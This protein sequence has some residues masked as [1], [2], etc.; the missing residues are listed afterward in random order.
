MALR[1]SG[2]GH[3]RS[4]SATRS[5][6]SRATPGWPTCHWLEQAAAALDATDKVR[7]D[8]GAGARRR[9]SSRP[10]R[11]VAHVRTGCRRRRTRPPAGQRRHRAGP[12]RDQHVWPR[13]HRAPRYV[14]RVG[15]QIVV[16][17]SIL[18]A[19]GRSVSSIASAPG[20]REGLLGSVALRR[21]RAPGALPARRMVGPAPTA[22]GTCRQRAST[23]PSR[24]ATRPVGTC[25]P[26]RPLSQP[27]QFRDL[28][29]QVPLED[30]G[31][32]RFPP[33]P[34]C[35]RREAFRPAI[36]RRRDRFLGRGPAA[37]TTAAR[38][39]V[40]TPACPA[41]GGSTHPSRHRTT[42]TSI[43]GSRRGWWQ[44]RRGTSPS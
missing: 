39:I 38:P 23:R 34:E 30:L 32:S 2:L 8:G 29:A 10:R 41:C 21:C 13:D 9:R 11:P 12:D 4:S 44:T 6:A 22:I 24:S 42:R 7:R 1:V 36:H 40:W 31:E 37:P 20:L 3:R 28:R 5:A 27:L 18:A 16:R 17:M 15:I 25:G 14:P 43:H 35:G 19:A 26:G 33:S